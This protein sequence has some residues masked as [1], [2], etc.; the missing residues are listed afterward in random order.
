MFNL[1]TFRT[2]EKQSKEIDF[3]S[4]A[5]EVSSQMT[6]GNEQRGYKYEKVT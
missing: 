2:V 6:M 5:L 4:R 1:T 3:V